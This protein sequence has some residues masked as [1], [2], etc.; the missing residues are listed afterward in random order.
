MHSSLANLHH[1]KS[2]TKKCISQPIF[3]DKTRL[4]RESP[5]LRNKY[6]TDTTLVPS[7]YEKRIR[8]DMHNGDTDIKNNE[9]QV[10]DI[11]K[12][13]NKDLSTD[14]S[15]TWNRKKG[16]DKNSTIVYCYPW[17][18]IDL[19]DFYIQKVESKNHE[20]ACRLRS[21]SEDHRVYVAEFKILTMSTAK[22]ES[23]Q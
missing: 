7:D 4:Y 3:S 2:V 11:Q 18:T 10:S 9:P 8:L 12:L 22:R 17:T 15:V 23:R 1:K 13:G 5:Q 19:C 6:T 16:L 14:Y 20:T 21:F